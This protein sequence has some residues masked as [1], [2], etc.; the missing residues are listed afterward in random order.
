[1][2]PSPEGKDRGNLSEHRLGG[3]GRR[4]RLA[5][6]ERGGGGGVPHLPGDGNN[7]TRGSEQVLRRLEEAGTGEG[8]GGEGRQS[9]KGGK[10][11]R[12]PA[13]APAVW[14]SAM[15]WDLDLF[16]KDKLGID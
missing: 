14:M 12:R 6:E 15:V 10:G 1:M 16:L 2:A 3:A 8:V 11:R 13:S 9:G 5:P 7:I 4:R